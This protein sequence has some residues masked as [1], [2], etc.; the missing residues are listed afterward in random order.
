VPAFFERHHQ[1]GR[2]NASGDTAKLSPSFRPT[3]SPFPFPARH[4]PRARGWLV[5]RHGA[6]SAADVGPPSHHRGSVRGVPSASPAPTGGRA[7]RI[8][9]VPLLFPA[10]G[11]VASFC[12]LILP[13]SAPPRSHGAAFTFCPLP[14]LHHSL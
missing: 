13:L 2:A 12:H 1:R 8:S 3:R 11:L 10:T 4:L 9:F 7:A 14:R 6:L 5:W